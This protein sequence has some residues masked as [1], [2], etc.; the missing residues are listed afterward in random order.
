MNKLVLVQRTVPCA[1]NYHGF[2][3]KCGAWYGVVKTPFGAD[4]G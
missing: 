3:V 4:G 2:T 1:L